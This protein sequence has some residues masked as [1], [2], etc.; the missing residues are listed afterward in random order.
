MKIDV[1]FS[2]K[3]GL[4]NCKRYRLKKMNGG[5]FLTEK[6]INSISIF[7]DFSSVNEKSLNFNLHI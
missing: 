6:E 4:K 3:I 5:T 2:K 1:V 7:I